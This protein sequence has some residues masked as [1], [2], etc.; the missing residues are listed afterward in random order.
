MRRQVGREHLDVD[1]FFRLAHV[2]S[3]T[4]P[5]NPYPALCK[6]GEGPGTGSSAVHVCRF[7]YDITVG[8]TR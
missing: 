5:S 7:L 1:P 6:Q 8:R 4:R 2:L 3:A